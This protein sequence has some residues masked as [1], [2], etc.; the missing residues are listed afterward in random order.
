MF[1]QDISA[2]RL[3]P[4]DYLVPIAKD[5]IHEIRNPQLDFVSFPI[6][7]PPHPEE[8]GC[9]LSARDGTREWTK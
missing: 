6:V 7:F 9:E 8:N 2:R 4:F 1:L 5:D 3:L